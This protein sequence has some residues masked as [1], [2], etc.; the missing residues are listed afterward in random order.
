MLTTRQ[1]VFR[2][3]AVITLLG[4]LFLQLL[5]VNLR[6]S[7]SW[8]EGHHLFDGYTI[9]KHHDFDLN[10]EVPPF[11]KVIAALPVLPLHL[12][13][14]TRNLALLPCSDRN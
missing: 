1:L 14:P 2:V 8:D 11:A 12:Y 13:E 6:T 10:P 3:G 7:M 4:M 9:L 5:A